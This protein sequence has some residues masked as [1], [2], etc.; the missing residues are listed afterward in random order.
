MEELTIFE[1]FQNVFSQLFSSYFLINL[2]GFM[3]L[4]IG[5]YLI[6][7]RKRNL[8]INILIIISW[9][10]YMIAM[11]LIAFPQL[12]QILSLTMQEILTQFYFPSIATL[13]IILIVTYWLGITSFLKKEKTLFIGKINKIFFIW[14]NI[15][16]SL[17]VYQLINKEW[18]ISLG[19]VLY[20]EKDLL[21]ILELITFSF[22]LL[23]FLNVIAKITSF[24]MKKI[25]KKELEKES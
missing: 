18:D 24:I 17:L 4:I 25:E 1:I 8:V 5:T 14:L 13:V 22:A 6:S 15:L 20:K 23:I 12:A 9:A 16:F 21:S 2:I 3:V 11:L 7:R 10:C 19:I